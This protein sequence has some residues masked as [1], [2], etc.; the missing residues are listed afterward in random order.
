MRPET[1]INIA[2]T[3]FF[4]P[5]IA[6]CFQEAIQKIIIAQAPPSLDAEPYGDFRWLIATCSGVPASTLRIKS[7]AGEIP[8]VVKFGRRVLYDKLAVLNWLRSQTRKPA[9]NPAELERVAD[10]QI[11]NRLAKTGGP[12]A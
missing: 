3:E 7:A 1:E 11:N 12:D 8:G 5:I 9:T 4:R 10:K 6:H 2:L